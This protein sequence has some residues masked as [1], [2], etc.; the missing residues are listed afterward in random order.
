MST[1]TKPPRI[2]RRFVIEIMVSG[3]SDGSADA[4]ESFVFSRWQSIAL[5]SSI[6]SSRS[7]SGTGSAAMASIKRLAAVFNPE[8]SSSDGCAA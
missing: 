6:A 2:V 4:G 8:R 3:Y 1:K 7:R 5:P